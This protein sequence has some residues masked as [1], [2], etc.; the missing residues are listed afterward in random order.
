MQHNTLALEA[1]A[2]S[3]HNLRNA[4][5]KRVA[6]WNMSNYTS[7]KECER[8][9]SLGTVNDLIGND[10]VTGLDLLLQAADG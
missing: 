9:D 1:V 2:A 5:I 7:L 6:E 10:E 8:T 4:L 3:P